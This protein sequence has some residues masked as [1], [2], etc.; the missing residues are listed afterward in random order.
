[1]ARGFLMRSFLF[2][3]FR[4]YLLE[5]EP[6]NIV[7]TRLVLLVYLSCPFNLIGL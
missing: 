2:H 5:K 4:F 1:M 6:I 7:M 3:L